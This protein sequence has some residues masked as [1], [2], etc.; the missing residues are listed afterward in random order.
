MKG[1]RVRQHPHPSMAS[2][3]RGAPGVTLHAPCSGRAGT[4][5]SW[6][7]RRGPSEPPSLQAPPVIA[8][9]APCVGSGRGAAG[10]SETAYVSE[11]TVTG[12]VPWQKATPCSLAQGHRQGRRETRHLAHPASM[13]GRRVLADIPHLIPGAGSRPPEEKGPLRTVLPGSEARS[14][15]LLLIFSHGKANLIR[16][17]QMDSHTGSHPKWP[18]PSAALW[19]PGLQGQRGPLYP[20]S[21]PTRQESPSTVT[22]LQVHDGVLTT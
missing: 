11:T 10:L 9:C 14:P 20:S 3:G 1:H 21:L 12:T 8:H 5:L 2:G 15:S 18:T 4:P 7:L 6:P 13:A 19:F 16:T 17:C 22:L